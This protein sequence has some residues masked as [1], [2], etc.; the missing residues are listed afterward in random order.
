MRI[1]IQYNGRPTASF[2]LPPVFKYSKPFSISYGPTFGF[3][4]HA[5]LIPT[6]HNFSFFIALGGIIDEKHTQNTKY[7]NTTT[8]YEGKKKVNKIQYNV[9][10]ALATATTIAAVTTT[11][12]GKHKA[13]KALNCV[14]SW[15]RGPGERRV[16]IVSTLIVA[17]LMTVYM[18]VVVFV[19]HFCAR[20][21]ND[22]YVGM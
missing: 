17:V 18:F 1:K 9:T 8:A 5:G 4:L 21:R 19:S 13:K 7:C 3:V 12:T 20:K 22:V 11:R 6:Y 2:L 14:I 15:R 10:S 16:L